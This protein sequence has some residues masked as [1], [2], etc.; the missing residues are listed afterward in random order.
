MLCGAAKKEKPLNLTSVPSSLCHLGESKSNRL[1]KEA[2]DDTAERKRAATE[3]AYTCNLTRKI[4]PMNHENTTECSRLEL[5]YLKRLYLEIR[6]EV[7]SLS[8]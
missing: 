2:F 7:D 5:L 4:F 6:T 3:V 8:G 1:S